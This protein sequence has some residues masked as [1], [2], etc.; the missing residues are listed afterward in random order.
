MASK[1]QV[2]VVWFPQR[3]WAAFARVYMDVTYADD[4]VI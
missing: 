1:K 4:L 2:I 3:K